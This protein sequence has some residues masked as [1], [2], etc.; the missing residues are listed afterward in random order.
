MNQTL[1]FHSVEKRDEIIQKL[2]EKKKIHAIT[3]EP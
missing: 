1:N 2:K 3:T